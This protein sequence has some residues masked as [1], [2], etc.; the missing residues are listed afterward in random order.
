MQ[1]KSTQKTNVVFLMQAL[2]MF[3]LTCFIS[4]SLFSQQYYN[5]NL[6][7]GVTSS[8]GVSAPVGYAWSEVQAGNEQAGFGAQIA[9]NFTIADNL[10]P[11]VSTNFLITSYSFCASILKSTFLI[12]VTPSLNI[13]KKY[14]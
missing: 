2:S 6:S 7:T 4:L 14:R 10:F 9:N 12:I 5:G 13:Y 11:S 8:N 1:L 3:V